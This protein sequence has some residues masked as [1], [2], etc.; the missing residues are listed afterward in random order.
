[1][2]LDNRERRVEQRVEPFGPDD[3]DHADHAASTADLPLAAPLPGAARA[4]E[5]GVE[6]V[7]G[8]EIGMVEPDAGL[9]EQHHRLRRVEIGDVGAAG[10]GGGEIVAQGTPEEIMATKGSYTGQFLQGY[11]NGQ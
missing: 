2:A 9:A 5:H 1:M 3:A 10:K 4:A 6:D 8:E 7:D 11:L